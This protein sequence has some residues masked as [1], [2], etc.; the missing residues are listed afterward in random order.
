M[1]PFAL[2]LSVASN[3]STSSNNNSCH[4]CTPRPS[5]LMKRKLFEASELSRK[6]DNRA[7]LSPQ[8]SHRHDKQWI[9]VVKSNG[10][11]GNDPSGL[12]HSTLSSKIPVT[13]ST[14]RPMPSMLEDTKSKHKVVTM[15]SP[16]STSAPTTAGTKLH[17]TPT[18]KAG[19]AAIA[20]LQHERQR[21]AALLLVPQ[22]PIH[23]S[24]DA[25]SSSINSVGTGA[26]DMYATSNSAADSD[27]DSASSFGN[28]WDW[29]P[30]PDWTNSAHPIS[31]P[32][33]TPSFTS[34]AF[35]LAKNSF[36]D[37]V[38]HHS[39]KY[40]DPNE[41]KSDP[42]DQQ[43]TPPPQK[44]DDARSEPMSNTHATERRTPDAVLRSSSSPANKCSI[45][46]ELSLLLLSLRNV[47]S[48]TDGKGPNN[49]HDTDTMTDTVLPV[50]NSGRRRST[51]RAGRLQHQRHRDTESHRRRSKD[52]FFSSS[53]SSSIGR[54]SGSSNN[55]SHSRPNPRGRSRNRSRT[56][57]NA[58]RSSTKTH[59]AKSRRKS[60]TGD[61]ETKVRQLRRRH[62]RRDASAKARDASR[63]N[64]SQCPQ[65][66]DNT[67]HY[68]RRSPF[69]VRGR[70]KCPRHNREAFGNVRNKN[71][72]EAATNPSSQELNQ[73]HKHV[74]SLASAS[75]RSL[76]QQPW[77]ASTNRRQ[78]KQHCDHKSS[79]KNSRKQESMLPCTYHGTTKTGAGAI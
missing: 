49:T 21:Q 8:N 50:R 36:E 32:D 75:C 16:A 60:S 57:T 71:P 43:N 5:S 1:P 25:L 34:T 73:S 64:T 2:P 63:T 3:R 12:L 33:R 18:S 37:E 42:E 4:S 9:M 38:K 45:A 41:R 54:S 76:E 17:Q 31:F 30:L 10:D 74:S 26:S 6:N 46:D 58:S 22:L 67:N 53:S 48:T 47:S 29:S 55:N 61:R 56:S 15:D 72:K 11:R 24:D 59:S 62:P 66:A 13:G 23:D 78:R 65:T 69:M 39:K 70:I 77:C 68:L 40:N 51:T 27:I 28:D 14:K 7:T 20:A 52:S 44:N 35:S 19:V 79:S